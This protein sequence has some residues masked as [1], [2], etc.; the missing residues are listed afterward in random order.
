M[1]RF[2]QSLASK[3]FLVCVCVCLLL[4]LLDLG[5]SAT[6]NLIFIVSRKVPVSFRVV[7]SWHCRNLACLAWEVSVQGG[8]GGGGG[9]VCSR[10]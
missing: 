1:G 10:D 9:G 6:S 4:P 2:V 5:V 8:G 3:P 7:Y